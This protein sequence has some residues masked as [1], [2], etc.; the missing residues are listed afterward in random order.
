MAHR[1]RALFRWME[2]EAE[3]L[4]GATTDAAHAAGRRS[5]EIKADVVSARRARGGPAGDPQ[6]RPHRGPRAR[7]GATLPAPHGEA[8]RPRPHSRVRPRRGARRGA[9]PGV[10]GRVGA[11]SGRPLGLA[12]AAVAALGPRSVCCGDGE[13]QEDPGARGCGS[14]CPTRWVPPVPA[15]AGRGRRGGDPDRPGGDCVGRSSSDGSSVSVAGGRHGS[16]RAGCGRSPGSA[17]RCSNAG[18]TSITVYTTD[19]DRRG[20]R[21]QRWVDKGSNRTPWNDL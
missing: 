7:A 10:R 14:R 9:R 2:R 3:A 21:R 11:L 16:G 1:R 5:V 6:R 17:T 20:T 13:R 8:V 19:A 12:G 4:L 15:T 18:S